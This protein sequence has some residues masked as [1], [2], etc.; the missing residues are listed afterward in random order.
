MKEE[1]SVF[2]PATVSNVGPGFD[3]MGFALESPGDEMIVRRNG[4]GKIVL[5][6]ES[7]CKLPLNPEKNVAAVAAQSLLTELGN[8]DGFDLVFK[9]KINPGSG[10]GSSAASCVAAVVGINHLLGNP[11]ETAALVPY[12]MEGEKIASGAVH[13]DNI[14]PAL[15]G[16]FTLIRGYDPLDIKHIPYPA[17]LW[18]AVVHPELE[19]KTMESRKL[20][21]ENI[22]MKTAL[23]QCGNLAGLVAGL[24]TADY[25]LISRS[26]T[27]V[28]AEP[29]RTQQLPGFK[30][31][32][33]AS[34]DA[35]SLGTGLSGSGPSV[36]SL[37]RGEDMAATVGKVMEEHFTTHN[38]DSSLYISIISEAGCRII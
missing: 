1:V 27:D 8:S 14:A 25:G 10:I 9:C 29:Y 13:A 32:R 26:V 24:A 11:F 30:R 6:D 18:C 28:F 34:L 2:G 36:F 22:P 21:P 38:I 35:G 33:Q 23:Q 16:G 17:D 3:L 7:G 15:L 12:A 19:I 37:C 20:I 31:L 4:S 5:V